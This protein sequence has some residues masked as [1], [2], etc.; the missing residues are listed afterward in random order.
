MAAS[1]IRIRRTSLSGAAPVATESRLTNRVAPMPSGALHVGDNLPFMRSLPDESIDLAY[2]DPP[3]NTGQTQHGKARGSHLQYDDDWPTIEDYLAFLRPRL[4]EIHRLLKPSGSIL[5]HCDWRACHHLR[6]ELDR[7]F[8]AANFVNHLIWSYG[9]GGSS[10]RR[11]ARKHD[12]LLFYAKSEA[13]FFDPPRVPATSQRLKGQRKKATDVIEIDAL[14]SS[15]ETPDD[16]RE[17][18]ADLLRSDVLAVPSLNNMARERTGYPTQKPLALLEL[19]V[20]ACC[21]SG[22]TVADFFC[23]SGTALLAAQRLH[24]HW[25]GCDCSPE[26]IGI[27]RRRL[28]VQTAPA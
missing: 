14:A 7:A 1:P 9:L 19:L 26:A 3:F 11:F 13:Y 23:G 10:P 12:D 16:E 18:M 15:C 28:V 20:R 6:L 22:G 2:V 24:R 5:L 21:P 17:S 4:A 25:I 27:A 8:G